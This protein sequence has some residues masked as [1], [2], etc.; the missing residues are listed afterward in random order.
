M[1][2]EVHDN[3]FKELDNKDE[4]KVPNF[5]GRS[6]R[7]VKL[8]LPTMIT[9]IEQRSSIIISLSLLGHLSNPAFIPGMKMGEI[10][11][12]LLGQSMIDQMN[13]SLETMI[14]QSYGN[15]RKELCGVH[16]NRA[17]FITTICFVPIFILTY[18][19]SDFLLVKTGQKPEVAEI[20]QVYNKIFV[21]GA[22][23]NSLIE[24]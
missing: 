9:A 12:K 16:L 2:T 15:G 10:V 7:I 3:N 5:C 23:I 24:T 11:I 4:D 8:S 14:S 22:Y 18:F 20:A 21:F 13:K 6:W 19:F 17:R 1:S